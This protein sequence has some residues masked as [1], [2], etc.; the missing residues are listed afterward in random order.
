MKKI[1]NK[2]MFKYLNEVNPSMLAAAITFYLL[3]II[4]PLMSLLSNILSLLEIDIELLDEYKV[5]TT[6]NVASVI[7]LSFSI[8]WVASRF[9]NALAVTSDVIYKDVKERSMISRKI[10]SVLLMMAIV[11]LMIVQ[12]V[13]ILFC[14]NFFRNI[15]HITQYYVMF[16]IQFILQFVSIAFVLSIVYKYIVPIKIKISKTFYLSLITTLIWYILTLGFYYINYTLKLNNYD[17]LYG[18]AASLMLFVFWLYLVILTLVY[19]IAFNY[20]ITK[21]RQVI[22]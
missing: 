20:Y 11:I 15:L 17:S 13:V 12:I 22:K 19:V 7:I 18:S 6:Q 9:I 5:T 4:V 16:V 2:E 8:I 21:K 1:L 14:L 3:F 10:L